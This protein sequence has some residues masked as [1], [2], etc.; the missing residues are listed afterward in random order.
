M[1]VTILIPAHAD[2]IGSE[3]P[4]AWI[5]SDTTVSV[6]RSGVSAI[7][8]IPRATQVWVVIPVARVL[9]T[10]LALPPVSAARLATL[11]PF[12]VED[13]LMSD[14]AT[15]HAVASPVKRGRESVV[16]VIDKALA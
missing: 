14:P 7:S 9:F 2:I 8:E 13:K 5:L 15:I 1:I 12:A 11:L 4:C 6:L 3:T 16:A 10:E